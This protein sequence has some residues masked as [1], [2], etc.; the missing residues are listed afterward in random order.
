M[1]VVRNVFKCKPGGASTVAEKL[2]KANEILTAQSGM[3]SPRVLVDFVGGFWTVVLEHEV[4]SLSQ[5]EEQ[6]AQYGQ[7][8]DVQAVM[9]GYLDH[10][11]SGYREIFRIA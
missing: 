3:K 1:L 5:F 10:V 9:S 4:E 7:R 11:Q 8:E 6:F 2:K